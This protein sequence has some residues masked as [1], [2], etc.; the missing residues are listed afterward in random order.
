MSLINQALRKAQRDRTPNRMAE[1]GADGGSTHAAT[2]GSGMKPGLVIGLVVVVALLL[3]L[4]AGLSIVLLK[5][6]EPAAVAQQASPSPEKVAATEPAP[7]PSAPNET[8]ATTPEPIEPQKTSS[9]ETAALERGSKVPLVEELRK[10][11]EAAEAKAAAEAQ[12]AREAAEAAAAKAAAE[13]S[14]EIIDWLSRA[15]ITGVKLSSAESKVILNGE[16]YAVG[17]YVNYALGLKVMVV[18]EKRV[19][20]V[21]D[22]GKKYLKRI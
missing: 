20:F 5:V 12:A 22:N 14:Q 17:E 1:P 21:D 4:V 7:A 16:P 3:G 2:G 19:L 9:T 13:P 11:R 6:G 10:A 8:G 15:K 18:Q